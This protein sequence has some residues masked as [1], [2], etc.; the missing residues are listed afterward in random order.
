MLVR[1]TIGF[2]LENFLV[3]MFSA[4][5][6]QFGEG[7]KIMKLILYNITDCDCGGEMETV[8][9]HKQLKIALRERWVSQFS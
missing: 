6:V 7:R 2:L 9:E 3:W 8:R 1:W 5:P 4:I